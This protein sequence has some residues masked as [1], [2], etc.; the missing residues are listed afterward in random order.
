VW[1]QEQTPHAVFVP[2][3]T[4]HSEEQT[5]VISEATIFELK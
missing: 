5:G 3:G 2:A 4:I 1:I